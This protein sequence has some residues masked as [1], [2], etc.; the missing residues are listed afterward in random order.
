MFRHIIFSILIIALPFTLFALWDLTFFSGALPNGDRV[1]QTESQDDSLSLCFKQSDGVHIQP[2]TTFG[3]YQ[4]V[5]RTT[6]DNYVNEYIGFKQIVNG[7]T[8]VN[9]L[10]WDQTAL[11]PQEQQTLAVNDAAGDHN[12]ALS[13]LDILSLKCSFSSDKLYFALRNAG[14]GF[15]VSSGFTYYSYMVVL[16]NPNPEP[17][18]NPVP[19]GLMFTVNIPGIITPGLY[20]L[21]GTGVNDLVSLGSINTLVDNNN[22]TLI[23]S[24][25]LADLLADAAFSN[26]FNPADPQIA[27]MAMTSKI[28]LTSGSQTADQSPG[29]TLF[30]TPRPIN[31]SPDVTPQILLPE[32]YWLLDNMGGVGIFQYYS[33]AHYMPVDT[34][35]QFNNGSR[36][37]M[38][39][40]EFPLFSTNLYFHSITF[41]YS[42]NYQTVTF[43]ASCD[44]V[45]YADT[46]LVL[47]SPVTEE[48]YSSAHTLISS[49]YPNPAKNYLNLL[50]S[51]KSNAENLKVSLYDL[52]GRLISR[53][54]VPA[55]SPSFRLDLATDIEK[56]PSGIYFLQAEQGIQKQT[57]KV[58]ILP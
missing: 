7:E 11:P 58:L 39:L 53:H 37:N 47:N 45:H 2:M 44:M 40:I 38:F 13:Y 8:L 3:G 4:T 20:K 19:Y 55:S 9:P 23:L 49:I 6:I 46:T 52:R 50:L 14:G 42:D 29:A 24:C 12:F 35:L 36:F 21:N 30:L 48:S 54:T 27:I 16:I 31:N 34:Y 17:G 10:P 41:P 25:N 15:P 51:A 32:F 57:K 5:Y 56:L 26:W 33:P 28:T 22:Q 1:V 43:Y 18:T